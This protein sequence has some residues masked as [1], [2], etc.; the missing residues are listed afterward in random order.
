MQERRCCTLGSHLVVSQ[1]CSSMQGTAFSVQLQVWQVSE[2]PGAPQ[3]MQVLSF[4]PPGRWQYFTMLRS[5]TW[6]SKHLTAPLQ[7]VECYLF[8]NLT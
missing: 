2:G 7:T 6:C 4:S 8:D 5:E 3:G 1:G